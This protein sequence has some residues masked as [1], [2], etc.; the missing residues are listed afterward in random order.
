ALTM[1]FAFSFYG[2]N[3]TIVCASSN[4]ALYFV[5]DAATCNAVSADFANTDLSVAGPPGDLPAAL[6]FWTD[7]TFQV[8][9]AGAVYY[10]T[11]GASPNRRFIVQWSNAYPSSSPNPVNFQV[12]LSEG[13][14]NIAFQYQTV[15]LGAGNVYNNGALSTVGVRGPGAVTNGKQIQ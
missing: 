12:I 6:P 7:L 11:I 15:T 9:G 8:P 2:T 10:Q 5:P 13:S 1:P 14:N 3:Y 4:G